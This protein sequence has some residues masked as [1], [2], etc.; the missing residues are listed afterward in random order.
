MNNVVDSRLKGNWL[1]QSAW[2]T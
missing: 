2:R 1:K